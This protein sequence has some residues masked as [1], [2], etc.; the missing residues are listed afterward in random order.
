MGWY[1]F[2]LYFSSISFI[3]LLLSSP[4]SPRASTLKLVHIKNDMSGHLWPGLVTEQVLP[5]SSTCI[6][7][8]GLCFKKIKTKTKTKIAKQA[9]NILLVLYFHALL[10]QQDLTVLTT[11]ILATKNSSAGSLGWVRG[12]WVGSAWSPCQSHGELAWKKIRK[13]TKHKAASC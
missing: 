12:I 13:Q 9:A 10:S 5:A 1:I 11:M 4:L 3:S 2:W 6:W 7:V 8:E